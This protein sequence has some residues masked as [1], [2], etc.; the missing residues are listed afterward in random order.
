M[1]LLEPFRRRTVRRAISR[2]NEAYPLA[3]RSVVDV[4]AGT[5]TVMAELVRYDCHITAV[6]P[7][8]AMAR[9]ARARF[10]QITV[11]E[12]RADAM[13]FLPDASVDVAIL[14]AMLHGLPSAYRHRV[15]AEL[16]RVVRE[17]VVVIDYHHNHN[18]FIAA[19]E[20]V[21]GG[22]YFEFV[23]S[24]DAE[25]TANFSNVQRTSL[26]AAESIW[27]ARCS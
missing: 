13:S 6:E 27:L 5:G 24:V 23:R 8:F 17:L 4:G 19:T 3:G 22:H 1:I 25:L 20:W 18:P 26:G 16:V 15:Y 2:L 21:E 9:I 7:S 10:P 14:A 11:H 12:A